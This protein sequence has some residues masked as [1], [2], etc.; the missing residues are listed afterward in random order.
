[1][2]PPQNISGSALANHTRAQRKG[3][4][5]FHIPK[6]AGM[7]MWRFLEHIFPADRMCPWWLWDQLIGVPGHEL[8][9]WDLFRGHFLAH[10]EPYLG[11][12]LATFTI[13]RDPVERTISHYYHVR[14]A[15]EHPSHSYAQQLSLAEF[16]VHPMTRHMVENYQAGYLAA[17]PRNPTAAAQTLSA[18]C[19]AR[20]ELQERMQYPDPFNDTGT[21]FERAKERL[22]GF[23]T[24]GFTED[25]ANSLHRI[26][27]CMEWPL[28]QPF[29][30]VNVNPERPRRTEIDDITINLICRLTEV[31]QRLYK[32]AKSHF[33][34]E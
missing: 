17:L 5:F 22:A 13:L 30:A 21:L 14:R 31:D 10:L 29:E 23:V 12:Q 16:C 6:T 3:V 9:Q 11:R 34:T 20:F 32:F 28:P 8:N 25:F 24:V 18:E 4:Y 27:R 1:M 2:Q 7:S 33:E 19:L 15:T 26:S